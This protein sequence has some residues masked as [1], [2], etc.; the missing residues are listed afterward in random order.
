MGKRPMPLI[1]LQMQI[2]AFY[3]RSLPRHG[4]NKNL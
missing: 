4:L 3:T 2:R 1:T